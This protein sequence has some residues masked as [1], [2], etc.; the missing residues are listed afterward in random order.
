MS[1]P[2]PLSQAWLERLQRCLA[3]SPYPFVI[4]LAG[5][6][7]RYLRTVDG[8]S[9]FD[10]AGLYGS[11]LLGYNHPRLAEPNYLRRLTLAANAKLANPDFLTPECVEFYELVYRLAPRA[12]RNPKLEVYAVN[13]GAEAVE[14]LLK[15]FISLHNR[16]LAKRGVCPARRRFVHFDQAFHGRTVYALNLTH[17]SH[18][19][20]ITDDFRG[21]ATANLELP[22][23]AL[24]PDV[25]E[26]VGWA[27]MEDCLNRLAGILDEH[28]EEVAGVL[29]EPI[30][31]AGGHR[32]AHPEFLGRLGTLC[33][34]HGVPWGLDEVQTA[35]GQC[36]AVFAADLFDLPSPPDGV[37]VAKKF[38]NGVVY[39][40][41]SV[42]DVGILDSTWGGS[43]ADMVRFAA[44]WQ[45]VEDEGLV[46]AA[47]HKG[48]VLA[49][50]L[51]QLA[52]RHA[53]LIGSVR[54]LGLYQGFSLRQ[55]EQRA[56]L[57][58]RA[59]DEESL[60]LLGA[61]T[62]TIRLRPA[63]D[64]SLDEIGRFLEIMDRLLGRL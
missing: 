16:R 58:A 51:R 24:D 38:G 61:G 17:L 64:V 44:E 8:E 27:A 47:G 46:A 56:T 26:A 20:V 6:R 11:R 37:A 45:I 15:Y 4:D 48:Q 5:S 1:H 10:W 40:L 7:G 31:G 18:A 33:H 63:L 12:M 29:V 43:L 25:P 19:P 23:P 2:G 30:Q 41:E 62:D 28:G 55:S 9:I 13:S 52:G 49:D 34:R 36:G 57:L 3:V 50:G 21:L 60:L 54:G 42:G 59:L 32:L 22:F 39:M 53:G 14:N 35:G